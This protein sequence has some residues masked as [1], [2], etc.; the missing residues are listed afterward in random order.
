MIYEI[1][2]ENGRTVNRITADYEFVSA[3]FPERFR[4]IGHQPS[5]KEYD[6]ALIGLFDHAAQVKQYDNRITCAMRASYAGPYQAEGAAFGKWMD[7]CYA[8]AY[9]IQAQAARGEMVYPSTSELLAGMPP[10]EWPI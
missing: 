5:E 4:E 3:H 7:E 2:D 9:A 6:D 1:T 8:K 10:M